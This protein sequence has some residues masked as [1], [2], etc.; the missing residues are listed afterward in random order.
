MIKKISYINAG[1]FLP[2]ANQALEEHLLQKVNAHEV[3]LYLWQNKR[4]VVIGRNQ[5]CWQECR[6]ERLLHDQ[7]HP[8]RRLSG[9]GAVFHDL[10]NINFTFIACD[11]DYDIE[12]HLAVITRALATFGITVKADGRNDLLVQGRKFSGNAFYRS[13][14]KSYHHG[15]LMVDVNMADLALYLQ[16]PKEKLQSKGIDSV[17]SRV[18][19]LKEFSP[20]ISV[21]ELRGAL[22]NSFGQVYNL[23]PSFMHL[24]EDEKMQ[25]R[26]L[27]QRYA[28]WGWI[29]GKNADFD[30]QFSAQFSWGSFSLNLQVIQGRIWQA[31]VYSDAMEGELISTLGQVLKDCSYDTQAI[32]TCL[33]QVAT[34]NKGEE[35]II[36]DICAFLAKQ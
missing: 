16:P 14:G 9:G 7:G 18:A 36:A 32:I 15:T 22:V 8:A 20:K 31:V 10:G 4:T 34:A 23:L 28:D 5:N 2:Y 33:Q 29:Y 26:L 19:N 27:E 1:S 11:E 25:I 3:I 12:R 30:V 13:G 35:A 6:V 17:R 24:T 21:A